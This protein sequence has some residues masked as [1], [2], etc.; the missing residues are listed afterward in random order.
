MNNNFLKPFFQ[1]TLSCKTLKN[2][3]CKVSRQ[4]SWD[5]DRN[6]SRPRPETFETE[7]PKTGEAKSRDSITGST[8]IKKVIAKLYS[9]TLEKQNNWETTTGQKFRTGLIFRLAPDAIRF[10]QNVP[11]LAGLE[12]WIRI[13]YISGASRLASWRFVSAAV[14]RPARSALAIRDFVPG[15]EHWI[16]L[17]F[18]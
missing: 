15:L 17:G 4:R 1:G 11:T 12:S 13:L 8:H 6:P 7:T 16:L 10:V 5:R 2:N 18:F 3:L 9:L 14:Q